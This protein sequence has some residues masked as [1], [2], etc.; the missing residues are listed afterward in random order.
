MPIGNVGDGVVLP[1]TKWM[2]SPPRRLFEATLVEE[3][4]GLRL[5]GNVAVKVPNQAP[6][7]AQEVPMAYQLARFVVL[8]LAVTFSA[9]DVARA[10]TEIGLTSALF[11]GRHIEEGTSTAIEGLPAPLV[12][13]KQRTRRVELFAEGLASLGQIAY[14][15]PVPSAPA[16]T[17]LSY[18]RATLRYYTAN[19]RYYAGIGAVDIYQKTGYIPTTTTISGYVGTGTETDSSHLSGTR[20]EVGAALPFRSARVLVNFSAVPN[21]QASL[22]QA[23]VGSAVPILYAGVPF[24]FDSS[25]TVPEHGSLIDMGVMLERTFKHYSLGYGLRNINY[26][27]KF[28]NGRL[29]DRNVFLIPNVN[30]AWRFGRA[31]AP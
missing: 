5:K 11:F 17:T 22:T 12:F 19:G 10:D 3:R 14:K 28:P 31:H 13:V 4:L 15:D 18:L 25:G 20:Y 1:R 27:A 26:S 29:A 9:S 23:L 8:V 6:R 16:W 7:R 24:T 30:L 21:L 2:E